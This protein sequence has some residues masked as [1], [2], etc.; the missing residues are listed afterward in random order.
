MNIKEQLE[1]AR[2]LYYQAL[3]LTSSL[4]N[5]AYQT[6]YKSERHDRLERL[7]LKNKVR[8]HLRFDRVLKLHD[9]YIAELGQKDASFKDSSLSD[10]TGLA[11]SPAQPVEAVGQGASYECSVCLDTGYVWDNDEYTNVPCRDCGA[12]FEIGVPQ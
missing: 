7:I 1:A 8:I 3:D 5:A 2:V 9:A 4:N 11:L 10:S 6:Q 12:W